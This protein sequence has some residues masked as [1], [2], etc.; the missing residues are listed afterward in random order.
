MFSIA[1]KRNTCWQKIVPVVRKY[2]LHWLK[3]FCVARKILWCHKKVKAGVHNFCLLGE[4]VFF[5]QIFFMICEYVRISDIHKARYI[6][7]HSC[8]NHKIKNKI[9]CTLIEPTNNNSLYRS[10]YQRRSVKRGVPKIFSN[11]TE[12]HLCWSIFL[13]KVQV[14]VKLAKLLRTPILKNICKRLLL[15][16][17]ANY[18]RQNFHHRH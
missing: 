15:L 13:I 6:W 11:F 16:L 12:K 4:R 9:L 8:D 1:Q 10:S 2:M 5:I 14:L 3:K 7:D 17:V 18:N